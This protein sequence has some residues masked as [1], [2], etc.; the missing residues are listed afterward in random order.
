[1]GVAPHLNERSGEAYLTDYRALQRPLLHPGTLMAHSL[2]PDISYTRVPYLSLQCDY[3]VDNK[4]MSYNKTVTDCR[5]GPR[6]L[7]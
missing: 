3:L 7:S 5:H 6:S 2:P 4:C 1:V